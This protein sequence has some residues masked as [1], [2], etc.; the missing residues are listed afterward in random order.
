MMVSAIMVHQGLQSASRSTCGK[1]D[2]K[3][4]IPLLV[5]RLHS[6]TLPAGPARVI[7]HVANVK[8]FLAMRTDRWGEGYDPALRLWQGNVPVGEMAWLP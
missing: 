6:T 3:M 2:Q 4:E 7:A 8:E 5:V 1:V